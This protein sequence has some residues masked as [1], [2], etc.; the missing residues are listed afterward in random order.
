MPWPTT[1]V[2][3]NYEATL[4]RKDGS[5]RDVMIS[6]SV[7]WENGRFVHTRCFTTD[8][9]DKKRVQ[10]RQELLAREVQHRTKN[11]FSV[12]QAVVARSFSNKQTVA[13]AE[14]AVRS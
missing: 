3:H 12:L 10:A 13:E 14:E 9:T 6:S 4:R 11:L 7:L 2:L 1:M 8:V 5:V